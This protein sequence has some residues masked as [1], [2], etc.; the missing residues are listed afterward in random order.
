MARIDDY[1]EAVTWRLR[2]DPELHMDIA[3]EVRTHLEDAVEQARAA[4][5]SEEECIAD[6]L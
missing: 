4:G 6:A 5:R 3:R 1:V 2:G